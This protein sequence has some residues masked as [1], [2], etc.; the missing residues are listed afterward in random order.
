MIWAK[1]VTAGRWIWNNPVQFAQIAGITALVFAV[2]YF[3]IR[4]QNVTNDNVTLRADITTLE[5]GREADEVARE[6][7]QRGLAD[8]QE[9]QAAFQA[10]L[11]SIQRENAASQRQIA[12]LVRELDAIEIERIIADDP[13]NAGGVITARFA[14]L[15]RLL[16]AATRADPGG[17]GDTGA[18]E[19]GA[20]PTGAGE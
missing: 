19:T 9:A 12:A 17:S 4:L 16:D 8:F 20:A 3:Y 11:D 1:A 15:D 18:D 10:T 13:D 2:A 5:I 7:L 14:E 6:A